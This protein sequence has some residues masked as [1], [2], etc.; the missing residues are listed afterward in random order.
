MDSNLVVKKDDLDIYTERAIDSYL[1]VFYT[2]H[3]YIFKIY[4]YIVCIYV[5]T[6]RSLYVYLYT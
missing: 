2:I 5:Y 1:Y 3:K 6:V 4:R